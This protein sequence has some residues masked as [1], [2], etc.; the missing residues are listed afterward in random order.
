MI[1]FVDLK[2]FLQGGAKGQ[3]GICRKI[4]KLKTAEE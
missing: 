4:F 1:N 2:F 3:Q